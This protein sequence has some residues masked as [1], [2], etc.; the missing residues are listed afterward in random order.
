ML[1]IHHSSIPCLKTLTTVAASSANAAKETPEK[2][3]NHPSF[4][5]LS[6][7]WNSCDSS[8]IFHSSE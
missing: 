4:I 5:I 1:K 8:Q 2:K 6:S 3:T 7:F